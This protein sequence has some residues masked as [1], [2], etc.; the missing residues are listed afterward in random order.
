MTEI[1][2]KLDLAAIPP[3]NNDGDPYI[4]PLDIYKEGYQAYNISNWFKGRVGDNGTPFAIR[5]YSHGRLLNIQGMRPFI[6][7]QVGDYTI[8]DSDPDNIR[9][10]MAED[11][12]NIHIVG[13]VDD[14]QAG[15]VAIYRLI[16]QAFPKSG[17]FYGKI[18]FMGTQD[19][20]T[21]VNTGVDIVFKVLADHMNMLGARQFYVS[22]LEKAW[23][24][25]QA[26]FKGYDKEY[27]A[28]LD[29]ELT[30]LR[31]KILNEVQRAEDTLGDTQAAIDNNIAG[32]KKLAAEIASL[33]V[34]IETEDL[35]TEA[36]Y[37]Q[38]RKYIVNLVE[39]QLANLS[40]S[41]EYLPNADAIKDKYPNGEKVFAV[42][43]DTGHKWI[44]YDGK[45]QDCGAYDGNDFDN[46]VL[47]GY[48]TLF[49]D[50]K[51]TPEKYQDLNTLEVNRI[52]GYSQFVPRNAPSN[53]F[54]GFVIDQS[55]QA[56]GIELQI[57]VDVNSHNIYFRTNWGGTNA[58]PNSW[59][60]LSNSERTLT[61]YGI[62]FWDDKH[63]PEKYQDLNTVDS[64]KIYG[65]SQF[66]PRNAPTNSFNGFIWDMTYQANAGMRLQFAIDTNSNTLSFRTNWGG[67]GFNSWVS[68]PD[69][70]NSLM[71]YP[72]LF[73]DDK[74]TPEKYQDLNTLDINRIYGYSGFVPKNAPAPNFNGQV[75]T[76]GF[77]PSKGQLVTQIAHVENLP[78]NGQNNFVDQWYERHSWD[79]SSLSFSPWKRIDSF[80]SINSYGELFFNEESCPEN[81]KDLNDL[82]Q[83]TIF[84]F[85][86]VGDLKHSVP[87]LN[88]NGLIYNLSYTQEKNQ[89]FV[90]Y[91][92]CK[93]D[94]GPIIAYRNYWSNKLS[95]WIVDN[96]PVDFYVDAKNQTTDA[97]HFTKLVDA[98]WAT[99]KTQHPVIIHIAAGT[100]DMYQ[101]FGGETFLKKLDLHTNADDFKTEMPMLSN[102]TIIGEGN[103]KLNYLPDL[104]TAEKYPHAASIISPINVAGKFEMQNVDIEV[105]YGRY[106][107]HDDTSGDS[108]NFYKSHKYINVNCIYHQSLADSIGGQA[109]GGG[110]DNGQN[111]L[112]Q[113]CSFESGAKAGL[114]FH[115]RDSCGGS[116][117]FDNCFF[118]GK[119]WSVRFGNVGKQTKSKAKFSSCYF[120]QKIYVNVETLSIESTNAYALTLNNCNATAIDFDS[121][122]K[123]QSYQPKIYNALGSVD[124]TVSPTSTANTQPTSGTAPATPQPTTPQAQ[125]TEPKQ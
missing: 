82:P 114:S 108:A 27:N 50:D 55:Y 120:A 10:D 44:Y 119:D 14:T 39:T 23:L 100:Y 19:D 56:T 29:Q 33:Q 13:D 62:L 66:V 99:Q 122:L 35:I 64:N 20:G 34:K 111:Y 63:T 3:T 72:Q 96:K 116:F 75:L 95:P 113:N 93:D 22:E 125:P 1:N 106:C 30:D 103:V 43:A 49:W 7:G 15:G 80:N 70:K 25:L 87:G 107:I 124:K 54:N 117:I 31:A 74:H 73:W 58:W 59:D 77:D 89:P 38:D 78:V 81:L 109:F 5:W 26:K 48:G 67:K 97:Q 69:K 42:A 83:N 65:Y 61:S 94:Y 18:G 123:E 40:N 112:F 24:D 105:Q 68:L 101:E 46:N 4:L 9:I 11:A 52:Y 121:N 84:G 37:N 110:F 79:S 86:K 2:K 115:N 45:W 36:Q 12:S 17:I 47:A 90:Q 85:D 41:I 32:L 104:N 8:D 102:V 60:C 118:S 51:H 6:E 53:V 88:F 91:A 21:L 28:K 57:A 92:I 71:S 76:F 16:N 98:M